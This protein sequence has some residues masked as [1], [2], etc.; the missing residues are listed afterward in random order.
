MR[1]RDDSYHWA[2][3]AVRWRGR[4]VVG[5]DLAGGEAGFPPKDHL[6][7]FEMIQRS[8]FNLTIHAG[9]AY[10][11]ESIWQAL[12]VCGAHRL[13]HGTRLMD[14]LKKNESGHYEQGALARSILDQR[15]PLEMCLSSNVHTGASQDFESHPFPI[16]FR[17]GYRVSLNTDD[18]LMSDTEL[19][20]ELELATRLYDLSI[21]DLLKLSMN[22]MKSSFL[23]YEDRVRL[24]HGVIQPRFQSI[25]TELSEFSR[26]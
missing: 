1:D 21:D 26:N 2:E 12:Q 17:L 13:G 23:P 7:A 10:G 9:E 16:L 18:R 22:A 19:S 11:L 24:M 15:I 14:D 20:Q 8:N 6:E 25:K 5:F 3:L 4:G